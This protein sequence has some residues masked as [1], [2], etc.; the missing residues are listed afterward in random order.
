MLSVQEV[1]GNRMSSVSRDSG[2][3][4]SEHSTELVCVEREYKELLQSTLKEKRIRVERLT[5]FLSE[6]GAAFGGGH[7][8]SSPLLPSFQLGSS[9]MHNPTIKSIPSSIGAVP[10]SPPNELHAS[11]S[12]PDVPGGMVCRIWRSITLQRER[13]QRFSGYLS[14]SLRSRHNST[15]DFH[16]TVN[17]ELYTVS[18]LTTT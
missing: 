17:D 8:P 4:H 7:A 16:S 5:D 18:E 6:S 2:G 14:P 13:Q 9:S 1:P 11:L 10:I 12:S 15:D 3:S